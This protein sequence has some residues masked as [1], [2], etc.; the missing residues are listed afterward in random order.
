MPVFLS[1]RKNGMRCIPVLRKALNDGNLDELRQIIVDEEIVCPISGNPQLD[2][3][4]TIQS[5]VLY[6]NGFNFDGA[7]KIYLRPETARVFL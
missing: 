5:H 2:R 4:A 6:R 7:L 3:S 1:I